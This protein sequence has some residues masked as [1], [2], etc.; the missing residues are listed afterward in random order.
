MHAVFPLLVGAEHYESLSC[1]SEFRSGKNQFGAQESWLAT[2]RVGAVIGKADRQCGSM[3]REFR[4]R[5]GLGACQ[6]K[7]ILG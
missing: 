1:G 3:P 4:L 5:L 2:F 7:E 6:I